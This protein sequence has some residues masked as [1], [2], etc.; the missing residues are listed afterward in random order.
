MN[1]NYET[2][3]KNLIKNGFYIAKEFITENEYEAVRKDAIMFFKNKLNKSNKH[4]KA[5]RGGVKAGMPNNL[6]YSDNNAW[7]IYRYCSFPWNRNPSHLI[8]IVNLSRK[9]SSIRNQING[10]SL[11]YGSVIEDNGFIQY[12][13]LSLYPKDG[14]FLN[15]HRDIHPVPGGPPLIHFKLELTH[16]GQDYDQGGFYIWDHQNKMH[17]ISEL[18]KPR[19]VIFF[20]GS[21]FHEIKPVKGELGR[22]ALFEIPTFVDLKN[23]E[24][25]YAGDGEKISA[26][27]KI[28]EKLKKSFLKIFN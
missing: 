17:C 22:I 28:K 18:V 14:G 4:L 26:T 19:D 1:N 13:S 9:L 27:F 10:C 23:R 21:L 3:S 20:D 8:N 15:K 2:I 16:K 24:Y 25:D 6:G 5:L 12:T 7:K 11:D